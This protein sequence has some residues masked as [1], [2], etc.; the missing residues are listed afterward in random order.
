MNN[1]FFSRPVRNALIAFLVLGAL[2]LGVRTVGAIKSLSDRNTSTT[3]PSI[4]VSGKG[5]SFAVPTVATFTYSVIQ[6]GKTVKEAQDKATVLSN[7][8]IDFLKGKGVD[9]KDIKT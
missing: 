1:D 7:K 5:E 3:K 6:D 2:F 9:I 8:A 4:T